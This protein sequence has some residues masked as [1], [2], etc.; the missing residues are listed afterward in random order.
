MAAAGIDPRAREIT[1]V[2][3][4]LTTTDE[5]LTIEKGVICQLLLIQ[6]ALLQLTP[7]N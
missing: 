2:L 6:R 4:R 7:D 3:L 5:E 1:S